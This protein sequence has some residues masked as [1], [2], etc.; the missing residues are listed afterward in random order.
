MSNEL[1]VEVSRPQFRG[2]GSHYI[3]RRHSESRGLTEIKCR[4]DSIIATS[5]VLNHARVFHDCLGTNLSAG[6]GWHSL[7]RLRCRTIG[8]GPAS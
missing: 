5:R 7:R 4:L 2:S 6:S 3:K 1:H 8:Y